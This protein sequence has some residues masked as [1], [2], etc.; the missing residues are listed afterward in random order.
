VGL[1]LLPGDGQGGFATADGTGAVEIVYYGTRAGTRAEQEKAQA[2]V[3]AVEAGVA[4][5]A[6]AKAGLVRPRVDELPELDEYDYMDARRGLMLMTGEQQRTAAEVAGQALTR[7]DSV[8]L[9]FTGRHENVN[10]SLSGSDLQ[11]SF[12]V[13]PVRFCKGVAG[14]AASA[15]LPT[16]ASTSRLGGI[17]APFEIMAA[18]GDYCMSLTDQ[19][20]DYQRRSFPIEAAASAT[21]H[22]GAYNVLVCQGYY[23]FVGTL[24]LADMRLSGKYLNSAKEFVGRFNTQVTKS[25]ETH[26]LAT[27]AQ[28]LAPPP[29]SSSG[30]CVGCFVNVVCKDR[31]VTVYGFDGHCAGDRPHMRVYHRAG[32]SSGFELDSQGWSQ[33]WD[34]PAHSLAPPAADGPGSSSQAGPPGLQ[35]AGFRLCDGLE[36]HLEPW[37]THGLFFHRS[38]AVYHREHNNR[39]LLFAEDSCLQLYA[40]AGMNRAVPFTDLIVE[41][42]QWM[43]AVKYKLDPSGMRM[44]KPAKLGLS[45]ASLGG[46]MSTGPS[47]HRSMA[48]GGLG[49]VVLGKGRASGAPS[50]AQSRAVSRP[51]SRAGSR[52]PSLISGGSGALGLSMLNASSGGGSSG[53]AAGAAA[54]TRTAQAAPPSSAKTTPCLRF[55]G[56]TSRIVFPACDSLPR[57]ASD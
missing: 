19:R 14:A 18:S 43:G 29:Y 28:L 34:E 3:T 5:A 6:A 23:D 50:G 47:S 56:R 49:A 44:P 11:L 4:D 1:G 22:Q 53:G 38:V 45:V 40:A 35:P 24:S 2:K 46:G 21:M 16:S 37:S 25:M 17:P 57:A 48:A 33:L 15:A 20:V 42:R 30:G 27:H 7:L 8:E 55:D 41:P 13:R 52:R 31:A 26:S 10:K 39:N 9:T 32:G 36:L 51:A 54:G 12:I